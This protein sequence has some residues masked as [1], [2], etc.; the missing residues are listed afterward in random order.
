MGDRKGKKDENDRGKDREREREKR[1]LNDIKRDNSLS[2]ASFL[3]LSLSQAAFMPHK[4]SSVRVCVY[5]MYEL[6]LWLY[7]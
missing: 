4:A 1:H 6:T 2:R 5:V 3:L 7:K